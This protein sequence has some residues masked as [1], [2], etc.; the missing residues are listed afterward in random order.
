MEN[1]QTAINELLTWIKD[2]N[3]I[4]KRDFSLGGCDYYTIRIL[5]IIEAKVESMLAEEKKQI[6][7]AYEYGNTDREFGIYLEAEEFFNKT[8]GNGKF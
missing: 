7:D 8:Y 6:I 5:E 4:C 1:K 3:E 2:K